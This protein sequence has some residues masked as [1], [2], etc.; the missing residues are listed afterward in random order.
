[1]SDVSQLRPNFVK[2]LEC[3]RLVGALVLPLTV[4]DFD[5]VRK[6]GSKLHALQTLRDI[7]AIAD[8]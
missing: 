7:V 6:S 3:V 8:E 1:M 4:C 5:C 2:R